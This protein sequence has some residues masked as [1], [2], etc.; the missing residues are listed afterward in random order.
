VRWYRWIALAAGGVLFAVLAVSCRPH[1]VGPAR[2]F[3]AYERKA[4]GT[5]EAALSS[6]E[7]VLLAADTV[8][9][10]GRLGGFPIVLVS[11]QEDALADVQGTFGSIQPPDPAS[12]ELRSRLDLILSDALGHVTDVR[13]SLR[14][15][16]TRDLT[17]V[18]LPLEDDATV[19]RGFIGEHGG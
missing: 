12:E 1:P 6:V 15:G 9:L 19:L 10:H 17:T 3:A 5:A 14:Q 18:A 16:P 11:G 2:D 13:I 8:T 7:T 4:L